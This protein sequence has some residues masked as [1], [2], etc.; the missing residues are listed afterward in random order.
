MR[1]ALLILPAQ[2]VGTNLGA[3]VESGVAADPPTSM[4]GRCG[5]RGCASPYVAPPHSGGLRYCASEPRDSWESLTL[6]ASKTISKTW[7]QQP[8]S[9]VTT[10][11]RNVDSFLRSSPRR[12][13]FLGIL[14]KF[15]IWNSRGTDRKVSDVALRALHSPLLRNSLGGRWPHDGLG[16]FKASLIECPRSSLTGI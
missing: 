11:S 7:H 4:L 2:Q 8:L 13:I 16:S 1:P 3:A 9:R 12:I 14:S 10:S 5:V 6:A 15:S